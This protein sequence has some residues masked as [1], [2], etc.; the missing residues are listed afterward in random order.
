MQTVNKKIEL[1]IALGK[2]FYI[3]AADVEMNIEFDSEGCIESVRPTVLNVY[4]MGANGKEFA[5][6]PGGWDIAGLKKMVVDEV[7]WD[8]EADYEGDFRK[9]RQNQ[10]EEL[11]SRGI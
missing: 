4:I 8:D 10:L 2:G 3:V 9:D 5:A 6:I 1:D 7:D 11:W